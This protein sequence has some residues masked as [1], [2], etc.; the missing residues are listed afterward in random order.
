MSDENIYKAIYALESYVSERELLSE[1]DFN[2]YLRLKD[3]FDFQG[4]VKEVVSKCKN[5]LGEILGSKDILLEVNVCFKLKKWN[6]TDNIVEY[7]PLHTS[8]LVNQIC[9]ASM[10]MPLMFDD[11]SGKR[12]LGAVANFRVLFKQIMSQHL[13]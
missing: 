1:E 12:N 13:A 6:S 2:L 3:K 10:L 4:T 11:S 7:R 8:C 9:M 5:T